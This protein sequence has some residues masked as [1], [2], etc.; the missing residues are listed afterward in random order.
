MQAPYYPYRK[1]VQW[2][3]ASWQNK[4]EY[5][6]FYTPV[7]IVTSLC[8]PGFALLYGYE[9][10][11]TSDMVVKVTGRQWYWLNSFPELKARRIHGTIA[12]GPTS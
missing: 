4:T 10:C 7:F 9:D 11:N 1:Q 2:G 12:I 8:L 5:I 3:N 6:F